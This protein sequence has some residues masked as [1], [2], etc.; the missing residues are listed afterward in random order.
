VARDAEGCLRTA[1]LFEKLPPIQ[2]T[3]VM[4]HAQRITREKSDMFCSK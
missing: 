3:R 1:C 2:T 4:S